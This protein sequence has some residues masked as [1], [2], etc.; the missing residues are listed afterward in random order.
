[1]K[2]YKIFTSRFF[3]LG[4]LAIMGLLCFNY[5]L[6]PNNRY[7]FH[8]SESNLR[9]LAEVPGHALV[10]PGNYD[11]RILLKRFIQVAPR[12]D[13][14]VI[15]GS[16]IMNLQ[17]SPG[18]L[19]LQTVFLNAG[20]SAGTLRDYIAIWQ[21]MKKNKKIPKTIFLCVD[22]QALNRA[23]QNDQWLSLSDDFQA[24]FNASASGRYYVAALTSQLKD[25]L[26]LQT[27]LAAISKL[28]Q[29][30]VRPE[31]LYLKDYAGLV[32][33]RTASFALTYPSVYEEKDPLEVERMARSNGEGEIKAFR[34]WNRQ[35][36]EYLEQL[37]MLIKDMKQ[38]GV[39]VVLVL[40]PYHPLSLQAIK[41]DSVALD[42]LVFFR[43]QLLKVGQECGIPYHDGFVDTQADRFSNRNFS[44]GVHLK[45][46]AN[47][48]FFD[49]I[50][51][52]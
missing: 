8:V 11:D 44:D 16:R 27:T 47:Q 13:T 7:Q 33:I 36:R 29:A 39:R 41:Q 38:E 19:V 31:L 20:V 42:N 43:D 51:Q 18:P 32:P 24:F 28:G 15:G 3:L 45:K 50:S 52:T 10:V 23:A 37:K 2:N 30:R 9:L 49:G 5:L 25:L 17:R 12:P 40:M 35:D 34:T 48:S 4:F 21:L 46:D 14:A 6:D 26:S 1:M 22:P